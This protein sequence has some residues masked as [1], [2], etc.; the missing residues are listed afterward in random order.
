MIFCMG[1]RTGAMIILDEPKLTIHLQDPL[2]TGLCYNRPGAV[3]D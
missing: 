2:T 3:D 1:I